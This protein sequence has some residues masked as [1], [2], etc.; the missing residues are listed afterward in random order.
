MFESAYLKLE[1]AAE[2]VNELSK[3]IRERK[4]FTY[5]L[6]SN[7]HTRERAT[8]AKKNKPVID[9]C[10]IIAGDAIHNMRAA[11]DHAYF[12]V[13]SPVCTTDGHR[14]NCQFP[15]SKTAADLKR[16]I[17]NRLAHKV[18]DWLVDSLMTLLPHGET[19]GNE[20]LWLVHELDITDKHGLL[21]PAGD[22][23][24]VSFADL[25]AQALDLPMGLAGVGGF[26][27]NRRDLSWPLS[28]GVLAALRGVIPA[29]GILEQE[30]NVPVQVVFKISEFGDSYEFVETLNL[31]ADATKVGIEALRK[32]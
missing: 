2:H 5:V 28:N 22:Y 20:L 23:T 12:E 3:V 27:G 24:Q 11:L 31:M 7:T 4:P 13:V 8:F 6:E 10:A 19:G 17:E 30:L 21:I 1:R 9:R 26:G 29:S 16:T 14:K 25:R 32:P 18:G 15:F